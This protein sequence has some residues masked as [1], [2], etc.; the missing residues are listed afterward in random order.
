MCL[1]DL[2][3]RLGKLNKPVI[4]YVFTR[5]TSVLRCE[6]NEWTTRKIV[7]SFETL[8]GWKKVDGCARAGMRLLRTRRAVFAPFSIRAYR[9]S[10]GPV[11]G[12]LGTRN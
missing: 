9:E 3:C 1:V 7:R 8:V 4:S 11:A 5:E 12:L 10:D 2:G 6:S